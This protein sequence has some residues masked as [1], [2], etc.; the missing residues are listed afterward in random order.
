[1]KIQQKLYTE[2]DQSAIIET[3]DERVDEIVFSFGDI[4]EKGLFPKLFLTTKEALELSTMLKS[5]V[6]K[7]KT[8]SL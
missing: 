8:N 4:S 2:S 1:M 5:M 7:T 6:D 3:I